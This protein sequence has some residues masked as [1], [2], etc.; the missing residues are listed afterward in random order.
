MLDK[1]KYIELDGVKYPVAF[2]L[3]V[4]ELIQDKFG[5]MEKWSAKLTEE[6]DISAI[7]WSFV[8]MINEGID[9]ENESTE[10]KRSFVTSKQAGRII[11]TLG[12]ETALGNLFGIA[13]ESIGESDEEKDS[14]GEDD[15]N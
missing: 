3:N 5:S 4:M 13:A 6:L 7:K 14:N 8:E 9:I 10:D 15:P 12:T 11:S 2:N 1:M